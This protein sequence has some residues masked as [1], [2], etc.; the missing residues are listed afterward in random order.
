MAGTD[1]PSQRPVGQQE[2]GRVSVTRIILRILLCVFAA[3][4][5]VV[6]ASLIGTFGLYRGLED[7]PLYSVMVLAT[8]WAGTALVILG[9]LPVLV[10]YMLGTELIS[11]RSVI[12][13]MLGGMALM[14]ALAFGLID[15]SETGG[16]QRFAV[17][18]AAGIVGGFVY[19]AIA[20]RSAGRVRERLYFTDGDE[21][22]SAPGSPEA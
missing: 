8:A 18:A 7:D 19:W 14:L 4:V 21:A 10:V 12:W 22:P 3:F 16:Q 15:P 9:G 20:G 5:A 11:L 6:A 13:H 2:A 1:A 17:A